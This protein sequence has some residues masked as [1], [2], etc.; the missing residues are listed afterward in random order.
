MEENKIGLIIYKKQNADDQ[1]L[2]EQINSLKIPFI[3]GS[4]AEVEIVTV[5]GDGN[6]AAAYNAG[7]R[8]CRARYKVY[9]DTSPDLSAS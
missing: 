4:P 6:R 3:S 9:L 2:M 5:A 1:L 8:Q 7:M